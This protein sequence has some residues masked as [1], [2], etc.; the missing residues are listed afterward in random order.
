MRAVEGRRGRP[1][2]AGYMGGD[3]RR[4]IPGDRRGRSAF[5]RE[6]CPYL[7]AAAFR[8]AEVEVFFSIESEVKPG[9]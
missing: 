3:V 6:D 1:P 5:V 4:Y 7:Y 2:T 8:E 9:F